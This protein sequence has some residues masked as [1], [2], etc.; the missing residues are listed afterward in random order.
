[1]PKNPLKTFGRRKSSGPDDTF[2]TAAPTTSSFRV[3]ERP[4][5]INLNA[6]EPAQE[7]VKH[8]VRPFNSPLVHLRGQS[9]NEL[10]LSVNRSVQA[11][12]TDPHGSLMI[13]RGSG[14]TTNSGSSGHYDSSNASA[15]HSSSSTI[16]S[17]VD[18]EKE[19]E[20][21]E[22]YPA[23]VKTTPMYNS[24]SN[25]SPTIKS[26]S[27][28]PPS[29]FTSR[30]A[31]AL[32]F[33]QKHSKASSNS[34]NAPPL[35]PLAKHANSRSPERR[36]R[37]TTTS[38]YAST[39]KPEVNLNL[40]TT[41]F[42]SEF[43]TFFD[44][45]RSGF[46]D[47]PAPPSAAYHRTVCTSR[48]DHGMIAD[49]RQ[50]SEP[51]FPPRALSRNNIHSI[52]ETSGASND[53]N[54]SPYSWDRRDTNEDE[55]LMGST[56]PSASPQID[57]G[58][59]VPLHRSGFPPAFTSSLRQGYSRVPE[60]HQSPMLES[61][62]GFFGGDKEEGKQD[63][64]EGDRWMR[65]IAL[66]DTQDPS[67]DE[68]KASSPQ[69][70]S[71]RTRLASGRSIPASAGAS[72]AEHTSPIGLGDAGALW[73]ASESTNVTPRATKS[74]LHKQE[75]ESLFDSSPLG[76]PSRAI[77][78]EPSPRVGGNGVRRMT[79]EQFE[80]LQRGT[81]TNAEHS[82]EEEDEDEDDGER[83]REMASRRRKQEANMSLYRQQMKKVI[84]G[85]PS[86][87]PSSGRPGLDRAS[88]SMASMT[89]GGASFHLGGLAGQPP[90][91][92][93]R[94]SQTEVDD[95]DVP[96]GIL[97]AHRFP[98]PG[99]PP[100]A[101]GENDLANPRRASVAL[102]APGTPGHLP[103]FARNLPA[104]PYF[105]AG[106]VSQGRRESLGMHGSMYGGAPS[107]SP[108][109]GGHSAPPAMGH[110][111]GLVGVIA[112]EERAKAARRGS[113]NMVTGTYDSPPLPSNMPT[114]PM[115][116][117]PPRTM[118]MG[119]VTSPPV[120]TPSGNNPMMMSSSMPTM[121]QQMQQM[122]QMQ[123]QGGPGPM[124]QFMQMQMQFMQSMMAMQQQS[125][126]QNTPSPHQLQQQQQ[127]QQPQDYLS[128]PLAASRPQSTHGR[129]M[130]MMNPP[131]TWTANH[132]RPVSALPRTYSSS[133]LNN[134]GPASVLP[135]GYT[136][137]IAPSERS[138]VGMPT[139]YRPISVAPGM[140]EPSSAGRSM[141]MTSSSTLLQQSQPRTS[142]PP[143][144]GLMPPRAQSEGVGGL[145][146]TVRVVDK[147]KGAPRASVVRGGLS[148]GASGEDED[149][150]ERG[151]AEMRRKREERMRGRAGKKAGA[152]EEE[153]DHG[154]VVY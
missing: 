86:D 5:T 51:M 148:G 145:K 64:L 104:D 30:A 23:R 27:H 117:M 116:G 17:S 107:I 137:S 50:D 144:S 153:F 132:Q 16:P 26:E 1:M 100:T 9:E 115:G 28:P 146:A 75:E 80:R 42:G 94:N 90:P 2:E 10:G 13:G 121:Q 39:A 7:R 59:P 120:Y 62:N 61:P 58:P 85:G 8:V 46:F 151:W 77:R 133:G 84:G 105:G 147:V 49:S 114:T 66:Y 154:A 142:T 124:E 12:Q 15:R 52:A 68:T 71:T 54:D 45:P 11:I 87:L 108:G 131:P 72:R 109:M 43:G 89:N 139:R 18:V 57:G 24:I 91:L 74:V 118:S 19:P 22:L 60:R 35:P 31:R 65:R 78:P 41:D 56:S 95:E 110:P 149:E 99:R 82:D 119:N 70:P 138:N 96:L 83:A 36:E 67:Y 130:T 21:D 140:Q 123:G 14:G 125:M 141:S 103:V 40:S 76:P 20:D 122:Q 88:T 102:P 81:D 150:D 127:Q 32:S 135:A 98:G 47:T 126:G 3:L 55:A 143:T 48:E 44:R 34:D 152:G 113:P 53:E 101:Q 92:T 6:G 97:Q 29:S 106:V 134:L 93:Q 37:A 33:G 129:A 128:V 111:A 25:T 69:N 79:K 73:A 112:G 4:N 136:P 38:S 63:Q